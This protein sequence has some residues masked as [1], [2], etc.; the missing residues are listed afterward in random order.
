MS[1]MLQSQGFSLGR[2]QEITRDEIKFSKFISRLR[3]KFSVLFLQT[4]RVQ[5]IAKG[6]IAADDW[7]S[8]EQDIY[9]DYQEDN[10]FNELKDAELLQNRMAILQQMEP[11][12]G[13]YYS[14]KWIRKNVL[15]QTDDDI[16][17]MDA[18]MK[19]DNK[20]KLSHAEL[21]GTVAGVTQTAQQ[22]YVTQNAIPDEQDMSQTKENE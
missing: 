11:Y 9:F 7:E 15:Q 10:H 16:E 13:R 14:S 20:D 5:L 6:V 2:S 18:E 17:V 8:L 3:K 21:D 19:Q 1:R 12:I 22:N 4:L